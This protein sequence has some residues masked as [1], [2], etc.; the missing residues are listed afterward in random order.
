[1][2]LALGHQLIVGWN[3]KSGSGWVIGTGSGSAPLQPRRFGHSRFLLF[4]S[5]RQVSAV[6]QVR[7]LGQAGANDRRIRIAA[8]REI[9]VIGRTRPIP[10][11]T[12]SLGPS[13]RLLYSQRGD[14][15][16]EVDR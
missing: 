9:W 16:R 1:V 4:V 14:L 11:I 8:R 5:G 2:Q 15:D 6:S 12:G 7:T 3:W 10:D 13:V